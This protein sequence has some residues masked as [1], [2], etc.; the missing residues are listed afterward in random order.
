[1]QALNKRRGRP[2]KDRHDEL[3][4]A[5]PY[6]TIVEAQCDDLSRGLRQLLSAEAAHKAYD[7]FGNP[8]AAERRRKAMEERVRL[9]EEHADVIR[10]TGKSAAAAA[11]IIH[12]REARLHGSSPAPRTLR[13]LVASYRKNLAKP[14]SAQK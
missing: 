5:P 6:A 8:G 4:P 7:K 14:P 2:R 3:G 9:Q 10:D 12:T 1:M 13:R 11:R